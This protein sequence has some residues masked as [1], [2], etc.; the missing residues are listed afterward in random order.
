M[1]KTQRK[2]LGGGR[3]LM[4]GLMQSQKVEPGKTSRALTQNAVGAFAKLA[5]HNDAKTKYIIPPMK[6]PVET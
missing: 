6:L 3:A 5:R 4:S 1:S 2:R